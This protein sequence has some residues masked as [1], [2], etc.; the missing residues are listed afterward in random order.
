[1]K[2]SLFFLDR[3]IAEAARNG[4]ACS[5][6]RKLVARHGRRDAISALGPVSKARMTTSIP[7]AS[8]RKRR[9][10]F[11]TNETARRLYREHVEKIASRRNSVTGLMIPD[12]VD[13]H[14]WI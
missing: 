11:Y 9:C 2:S 13:R 5:S 14:L 1:M 4:L 6:A 12:E 10:L 3:V 7:S 8:T